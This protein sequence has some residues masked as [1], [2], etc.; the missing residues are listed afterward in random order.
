MATQENNKAIPKNNKPIPKFLFSSRSITNSSWSTLSL[1]IFSRRSCSSHITLRSWEHISGSSHSKNPQFTFCL[2]LPQLQNLLQWSSG[3]T[4]TIFLMAYTNV[5]WVQNLY[6][7]KTKHY[8][9]VF[10]K[11]L[12]CLSKQSIIYRIRQQNTS[13]TKN[14]TN[15]LSTECRQALTES[16]SLTALNLN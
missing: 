10:H 12:P 15:F 13:T 16:N 6:T 3:W 7:Y 14:L 2:I 1:S 4:V 11:H 5:A 9:D 8:L